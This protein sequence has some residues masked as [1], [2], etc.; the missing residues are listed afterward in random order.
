MLDREGGT[1]TR[2]AIR[3]PTVSVTTEELVIRIPWNAM[4]LGRIGAPRHKRALTAQDVLELVEAGR[5]AHRLG[6]T[7][8][9]PSLK[10]L[11]A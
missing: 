8:S 2:M 7:R 1:E 9:V 6:K 4:E 10:D 3:R 5:L 11:L